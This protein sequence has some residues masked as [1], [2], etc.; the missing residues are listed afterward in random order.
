MQVAKVGDTVVLESERVGE[1]DRAGVVLEVLDT[2]NAPHY[3]VRWEDGHETTI[4]PT[5]G[6]LRIFRGKAKEAIKKAATKAAT[7]AG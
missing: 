6:S 3:R 7:K 5:A 2:A 1:P 4:F